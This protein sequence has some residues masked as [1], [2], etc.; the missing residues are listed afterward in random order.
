MTFAKPEAFA[1]LPHK[2][3]PLDE[4]RARSRLSRPLLMPDGGPYNILTRISWDTVLADHYLLRRDRVTKRNKAKKDDITMTSPKSSPDTEDGLPAGDRPIGRGQKLGGSGSKSRSASECKNVATTPTSRLHPPTITRPVQSISLL[5]CEPTGLVYVNGILH[6]RHLSMPGAE[7]Y[8]TPNG[9]DIEHHTDKQRQ[10]MDEANL[11][12]PSLQ[13][14]TQASQTYPNPYGP[15]AACPAPSRTNM[16]ELNLR[17]RIKHFTWSFF[18]LTMATGGIANV[19]YAVPFRFDGIY[20]IGCIFLLLNVVLFIVNIICITTRF[21]LHRGTFLASFTHPTESLFIPAAVVS[22][23]T[24]LINIS[25]YGE[26]HV[27]DWLNTVVLVLFWIDVALAFVASFGIYLI[28]WNTQTFTIAA[29]TPVWIFPAYPLLIIGPHAGVLSAALNPERG[30][31][32]IIGGMTCQGIGFMVAFMIYSAFIYR[33]MTQKLPK[34]A[35]R[36]GMFVS[37]GPSAFTCSGIVT[38]GAS[39]ARDYGGTDFMGNGD[40]TAEIIRVIANWAGLW[41]WGLALWFF[42]VSVGAHFDCLGHKRMPFAMT[43]FSFVFPQT[44][45][46]TATFA[47][48]KAFDAYSIQ[49]VACALTCLLIAMWFFVVTMMIRAILKKQILWPQKGEDKDEGGFKA[50][51]WTGMVTENLMATPSKS[52]IGDVGNQV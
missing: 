10:L 7:G 22:F 17:Q 3:N 14:S 33:L 40:M 50:S 21:V 49:V 29:M 1:E 13:V 5:D 46:V 18:T 41:F 37:V 32:I 45:L 9:E 42:C 19:L 6:P 51:D 52:I 39:A 8:R 28:I 11:Q 20:A 27:G 16:R 15:G 48:G 30:S 36:P 38:M 47:I 44:A 12:L 23:G 4:I 35:L 2:P 26:G 34:E 24:V 31:L 43:W 25:Q